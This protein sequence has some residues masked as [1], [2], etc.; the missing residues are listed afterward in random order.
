MSDGERKC[1][2]TV[3][4]ALTLMATKELSLLR[5]SFNEVVVKMSSQHIRR[6]NPSLST[7]H[8]N[9]KRRVAENPSPHYPPGS[10]SFDLKGTLLSYK[11]YFH[12]EF[13]FQIQTRQQSMVSPMPVPEEP[14]QSHKRSVEHKGGL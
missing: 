7:E 13:E 8:T 14:S 11:C 2:E 1:S 3:I 4:K 12:K 10:L 5:F 9:E 6:L